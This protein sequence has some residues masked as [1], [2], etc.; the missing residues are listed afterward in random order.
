MSSS[1]SIAANRRGLLWAVLGAVVLL[2]VGSGLWYA[3]T[4]MNGKADEGHTAN[5]GSEVGVMLDL[6]DKAYQEKRLVAPVGS[7]VY[8][9]YYSVLQLD[10]NNA[11]AQRRMRDAFKPACDVVENTINSGD[12]DEAQ[13]E[14]S[15]LRQY[16]QHNYKLALLGSVLDAQRV[17]ERR[18]HEAEAARIQAQQGQ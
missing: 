2:L 13:R 7:N 11:T 17:I 9:F 5:D 14:L 3:H 6:A 4:R 12:L 16:D 10:P 18:K 15:L 1:I 8:E